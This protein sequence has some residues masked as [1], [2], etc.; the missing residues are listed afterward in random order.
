M[1]R[2]FVTGDVHGRVIERLSNKNFQTA[3]RLDRSD[4]V[5]I[6]GDF[7]VIWNLQ[8]S[9]EERYALDWL[10]NRPF[11]T[12]VVG[13]NHENWPRLH[14]LY[15]VEKFGVQLGYIRDNVFFVPNG[16]VI[17]YAGKKIFCFGGA[18]STD[19]H[20]RVE[21]LSWW[22][23]EIPSYAEMNFGTENLEK[24]GYEVDIIITHTMPIRS[25]AMFSMEQGYHQ[26]RS[27][28]PTANYLSFIEEQT[29]FNQWFCGHF[30]KNRQY[31]NVTCLYDAI[32][33]VDMVESIDRGEYFNHGR[34]FI[35]PLW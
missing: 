14:D 5:F 34:T 16:T 21:G 1:N 32:V 22:A 26:E 23:E 11:T 7:G 30:H 3:K 2:I 6:A 9:A 18:M 25:I 20:M 35:E 29:K 13:G 27:A 19:R 12:L 33:D 17:E 8:E 10:D 24:H 31:G 4:L 15:H 28:D